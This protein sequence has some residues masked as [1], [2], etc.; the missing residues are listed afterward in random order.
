MAR[1]R[2]ERPAEVRGWWIAGLGAVLV[3]IVPLSSGLV[4]EFY[5][6]LVYRWVQGSLTAMSNVVPFALL[7]ALIAAALLALGLRCFWLLRAGWH[8]GP[9]AAIAEGARRV[10]RVVGVVV[11]A[12]VTAWGCNYRRLPLEETVRGESAPRPTVEDLEGAVRQAAAVA[13]TL[14]RVVIA[15][16]V[17]DMSQVAAELEQPLNAALARLKLPPLVEPGRPKTSLLLTQWFTW[18]GVNGMVNP[19]GLESIVHPDLL[20]SERPFV[21][22]HEWAHLAGHADEAEAN[23]IGW[24]ACMHGSAQLQYSAT[25]YLVTEGSAALPI[26]ARRRALSR[27]DPGVRQDLTAI[28]ERMQAE[29]PRVRQAASRVYD[30]Y[31]KANRVEDGTASYSRALS[32]ILSPIMQEALPAPRR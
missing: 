10:I 29:R 32:L 21:L 14:R 6:R 26:E 22:A 24:F 13:A 25:I 7:D 18:A 17:W 16:P 2:I 31:L 9:V 27:L 1:A 8:H 30:E 12:F 11:I 28:A 4:E 5:S 23:A 19:L 20:P 3:L 15:E